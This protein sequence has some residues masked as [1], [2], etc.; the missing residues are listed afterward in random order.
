[1]DKGNLVLSVTLVIVAL[2]GFV[3]NLCIHIQDGGRLIDMGMYLTFFVM[4]SS[5]LYVAIQERKER[6]KKLNKGGRQ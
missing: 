5:A 1:M 3:S 6:K 4:W 2:T